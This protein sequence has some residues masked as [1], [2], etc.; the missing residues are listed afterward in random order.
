MGLAI[1]LLGLGRS[2]AGAADFAGSMIVPSIGLGTI[3]RV[4]C[5]PW[6]S[7]TPVPFVG[8]SKD[9]VRL[10]PGALSVQLYRKR[11][12]LL[13]RRGCALAWYTSMGQLVRDRRCPAR[14]I[15]RP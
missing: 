3:N 7:V 11:A 1:A 10:C 13:R 15:R 5:D 2:H 4:P 8:S 12:Q 9:L 6:E 14:A